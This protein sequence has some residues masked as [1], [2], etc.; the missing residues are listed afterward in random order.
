MFSRPVVLSCSSS[1]LSASSASWERTAASSLIRCLRRDQGRL[2][3]FE[4]VADA[5]SEVHIVGSLRRIALVVCPTLEDVAKC[6]CFVPL[7]FERRTTRLDRLQD[8]A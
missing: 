6:L 7:E 8:L 1:A 4:I 3:C 2:F 5:L